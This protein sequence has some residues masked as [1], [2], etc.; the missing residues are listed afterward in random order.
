LVLAAIGIYEIFNL[1]ILARINKLIVFVLILALSL[2]SL[3]L[4][5][6]FYFN[7]NNDILPKKYNAASVWGYGG[8]EAAQYLN[9]LPNAE[10]LRIITNY[11]GICVFVK[12]E[13][14]MLNDMIAQK[15]KT[16]WKSGKINYFV[17]SP[18]GIERYR[19]AERFPDISTKQPVWEQYIDG[20]SENYLKIFKSN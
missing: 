7:Y 17:V 19:F 9:S 13:C 4:I 20:R 6:P 2:P 10:N 8:Y 12:G 15:A 14:A 5:R 11:F 16:E 1:W 3:F 18:E